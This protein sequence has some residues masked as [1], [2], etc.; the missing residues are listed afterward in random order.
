MAL[1][2]KMKRLPLQTADPV[3]R[4]LS[5]SCSC[6]ELERHGPPPKACML[7][8]LQSRLPRTLSGQH[9]TVP[10]HRRRMV[11]KG[12]DLGDRQGLTARERL[13]TVRTRRSNSEV[14]QHGPLWCREAIQVL[15]SVRAC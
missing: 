3:G 2:S 10:A 9:S 6:H 5:L 12:G 15:R 11:W 14:D 13:R 7:F 8:P 1:S 4:D